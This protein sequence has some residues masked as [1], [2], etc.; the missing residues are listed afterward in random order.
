M[1]S[2]EL[3]R[4]A[5]KASG[6]TTARDADELAA[7][8]VCALMLLGV[9]SAWSPLTDDGD[10]FRLSVKLGFCIT[11]WQQQSLAAVLVGYWKTSDEV[12]N[13]I[14][15]YDNDPLAATR[16]AIVMAAAEIGKNCK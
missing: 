7:Y 12:A 1:T 4:L 15:P 6:F 16:L 11:H 8:G 10:A 2:Y 3:L 5:A 14:Q 9:Q 13:I